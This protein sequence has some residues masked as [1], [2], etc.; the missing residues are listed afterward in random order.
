MTSIE[1]LKEIMALLRDPEK[2]CPWDVEQ[3]FESIA[4][5]TIEEAYEVADA[6][7]KNDM[8]H[9]KEE[10]GDLLL[11]VVFHA[12]MAS[13]DK[14]FDFDEVVNDLNEKLIHRHPHV[15]GD[16]TIRTAEEQ[17]VAWDKHKE[18]EQL[19]K[20]H[21][22]ILDEVALA[23]PALLRAYKLQKRAAKVGFD[24]P[25]TRPVF[26]KIEEEIE[27]LKHAH[28][29]GTNIEEELGDLLFAVVN[30]ARKLKVNPENALRSTN[31]KFKSRFNY[32]E[33]TLQK[34]G[35]SPKESTLNEMDMLW[36]EAKKTS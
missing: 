28:Q 23:L 33:K 13:E 21:E 2:G 15:F 18:V 5:H 32:I 7:E 20:G 30:L 29:H 35:K 14:L 9:L 1:R 34:N 10:L 26:E 8:L 4:P 12:Q 36:E 19:V 6:I 31:S 27:E 3:N 16:E 24:W 11:Q 22:S 17:S 25:D